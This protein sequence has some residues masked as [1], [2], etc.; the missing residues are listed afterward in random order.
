ML[1]F[2]FFHV[3]HL[4]ILEL[5][6]FYLFVIPQN[7]KNAFEQKYGVHF[8][9]FKFLMFFQIQI[10]LNAFEKVDFPAQMTKKPKFYLLKF[11][12]FI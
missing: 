9:I 11:L 4:Q 3:Y 6:G 8:V 12:A 5:H 7:T 2:F 1:N 10:R